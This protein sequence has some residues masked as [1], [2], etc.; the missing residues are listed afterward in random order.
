MTVCFLTLFATLTGDPL[1]SVSGSESEE[2]F[3]HRAL[4]AVL[5]PT[6]CRFAVGANF[7][8]AGRAVAAIRRPAAASA[9]ASNI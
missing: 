9:A 5:G 4:R 1:M 6:R 3:S 2:I 7:T 8:A